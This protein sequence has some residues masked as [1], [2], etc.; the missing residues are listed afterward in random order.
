MSIDPSSSPAPYD[1][2]NWWH[3]TVNLL[4]GFNCF[5]CGELLSWNDEMQDCPEDDDDEFL[6]RCVMC[7]ERAKALGWV[8][9]EGYNFLC[10]KCAART[11]SQGG[12][13]S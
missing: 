12:S 11:T 5:N 13:H 1:H 2:E 9:I 7:A 4:G 3:A 6:K 8:M 10:P